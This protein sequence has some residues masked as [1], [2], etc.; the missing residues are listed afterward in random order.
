MR[1]RNHVALPGHF[2]VELDLRKLGDRDLE[3]LGE[4]I[5]RYKA[6][7][8]R[9]HGGKVWQGEGADGL[10]WQAHGTAAALLLMACAC[11]CSIRR[12][13]IASM[14]P[15]MPAPGWCSRAFPCRHCAARM[16]WCWR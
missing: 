1:F 10:L 5:A 12:G 13:V 3:R 8:D 15:N 9:L 11:Q 2:G 6:L 4:G 14:K 7:R 16:G